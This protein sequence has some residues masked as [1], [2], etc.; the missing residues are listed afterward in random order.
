VTPVEK[1]ADA[2]S[3]VALLPALR[4][5]TIDNLWRRAL[6]ARPDGVFLIVEDDQFT[7]L[8]AEQHVAATVRLL[9]AGG[10]SRGD[11]LAILLDN[12]ADYVWLL[13]AVGRIGAV[14]VPIHAEAR[15]ELL[16]H[17]FRS[18]DCAYAVI[19]SSYAAGVDAVVLD[20]RPDTVWIVDD[21]AGPPGGPAVTAPG[22]TIGRIQIPFTARPAENPESDDPAGPSPAPRFRDTYLLM[23]TSGTS[24]P[25]KAAVVSQAQPITHA[26]KIAEACGWL[27]TERFYTCLPL[28]HANAQC[29]TLFPAISLGATMVLGRRFSVSRFWSDVRQFE[30]TAISLLGSMLQ[31]LWKRDPSSEERDNRV[32]TVLVVPFPQNVR[33]FDERY[34]ARFAT[35]YGLTECAPVSI[36]R[37]GEDYDRAVGMAGRVLRDHNDVRIVDDD[38]IEVPVGCVGE[39][40]VRRHDPYVTVQRYYGRERETWDD[41]RNL[42]FHTGDFG[43]VDEEDFLYFV[44]RKSDS[45]RRRG[46]NV[47]IRELEDALNALDGVLESAVVA[48]PSDLGDMSEDDIAVYFTVKPGAGL[49]AEKLDELAR[50]NLSRYMMP[51]Y[52]RV[53]DELPKTPTAK[54]RKDVLRR[55]AE[56]DL[57]AFLDTDQRRHRKTAAK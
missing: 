8:E 10:L 37:P 24:G 52:I 22:P 16:A 11:H 15:G 28:S 45:L 44:G 9:Q 1:S 32:S 26:I 51:R 13:L 33:E 47:S 48:V 25:S 34:D 31:L 36:S 39:I 6:A 17:F 21:G 18:T 20:G 40:L 43:Y 23:F 7:Y 30:C 57:G 38:D 29:H 2:T 49:D 53:V 19:G 5:R 56:S 55:E 12:R 14:A 42:W 27:P 3:P 46:E 4:D 54:I 35:L 41:F 50:A